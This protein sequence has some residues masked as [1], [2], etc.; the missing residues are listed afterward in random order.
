MSKTV[1][2]L[3]S[4]AGAF[5]AE[6]ESLWL[7]SV[8]FALPADSLLVLGDWCE[9]HDSPEDARLYRWMARRNR[10]PRFRDRHETTGKRVPAKFSWCWRRELQRQPVESGRGST[11]RLPFMALPQVGAWDFK[12]H[13]YYPDEAAALAAL[14]DALQTLWLAVQT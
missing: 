4:G 11:S 12:D 10:R 3:P 8:R 14:R 5:A 2:L 6:W 1:I 9:E 7:E 13:C